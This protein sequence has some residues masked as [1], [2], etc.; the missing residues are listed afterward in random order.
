MLRRLAAVL[1]GSAWLLLWPGVALAGMPS[2]HLA[3][4]ARVRMQTVSFFLMALL[5]SALVIRWL[6]NRLRADFPR[7][8]RLTYGKALSMVVL[9]GLLAMVVL[10][11]I[12]GARELLTPGAWEKDGLLYKVSETPVESAAEPR[13][14]DLTGARVKQ[15]QKL[16][17]ALWAEALK[18]D[19]RFPATRDETGVAGQDWEVPGASG[20]SYGY[21]GGLATGDSQA[22]LVYE[23][24]VFEGARL[25]LRVDGTVVAMSND[26]IRAA[27]GQEAKP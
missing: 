10:I 19:G 3:D 18:H 24:E 27:L 17:P 23:P 6:W 4:W 2:P 1:T 7:L 16:K 20:A 25:V 14:V 5:V 8:P 13:P 11:M 22:I 12:S 15:L 21:V 9:W 26:E